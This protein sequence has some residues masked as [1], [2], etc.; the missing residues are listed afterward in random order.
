MGMGAG[1]TS[2]GHKVQQRGNNMKKLILI[3]GMVATAV[4]TGC[5]ADNGLSAGDTICGLSAKRLYADELN[6][7]PQYKEQFKAETGCV[8]LSACSKYIVIKEETCIENID[9]K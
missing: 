1:S 9:V 8:N 5:G 4:L 6:Q 2:Y 7:Y 3:I